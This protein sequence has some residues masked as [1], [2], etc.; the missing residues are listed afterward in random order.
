M[1]NPTLPSEDHVENWLDRLGNIECISDQI[2]GSL[3]YRY[4]DAAVQDHDKNH[5]LTEA[6][7]W[8]M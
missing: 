1:R 2:G 7:I 5:G 6:A 3:A 8:W 4:F